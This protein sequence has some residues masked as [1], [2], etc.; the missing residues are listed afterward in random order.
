MNRKIISLT[1]VSLFLL[2]AMGVTLVGAQPRTVGV[3]VGDWFKYGDITA[4]WTSDDPNA[5]IPLAVEQL[6][7]TEWTMIS[8]VD[9]PDTSVT[10]QITT[11]LKNE[12]EETVGGYVDIDTGEGENMTFFAISANLGVN[13]AIY[14]SFTYS[15]MKINETIVRTYPDSTREIN[16]LNITTELNMTGFYQYLSMNYYWDRSSGFF[17]EMS[18]EQTS[19]IGGY[20]TTWSFSLRITESNVWAVPE[21]PSFLLLPLFIMATLLTVIVYRRKHSNELRSLTS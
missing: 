15:A 17:V 19:Q 14:S 10:G 6:N 12:T 7:N 1:L 3:N 5:T 13:D 21:F 4:N 9:V 18:Q 2:S 20:L 11:L 16:H 8:I